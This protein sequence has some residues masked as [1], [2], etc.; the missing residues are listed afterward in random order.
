M[1]ISDSEAAVEVWALDGEDASISEEPSELTP[2]DSLDLGLSAVSEGY[3]PNWALVDEARRRGW[4][5]PIDRM[6]ACHVQALLTYSVR[7]LLEGDG[8]RE[9]SEPERDL[10]D[11]LE[12]SNSPL[13]DCGQLV[14][15]W[16]EK[17]IELVVVIHVRIPH[18]R[19]V[20]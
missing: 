4:S 10:E 12:D 14:R 11:S 2:V 19:G 7:D 15:R 18:D 6:R 1:G 8:D 3:E 20:A 16:V 17:L 5:S 9:A 13:D